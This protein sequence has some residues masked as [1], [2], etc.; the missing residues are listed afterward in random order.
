[1]TERPSPPLTLQVEA[2]P[3][4][5]R[6]CVAGDLDYDTSDQLVER[7]QECVEADPALREVVLECAG[8]RV[9]DSMGVSS[10]LMLHRGTSAR[11]IRL[12]LDDPPPF[13]SRILY[14][15]GTGHLFGVAAG[16]ARGPAGLPED[17][18]RPGDEPYRSFP[19]SAPS[20]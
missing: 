2:S 12:S 7:F 18:P 1:M 17:G 3:G 5:V 13:L 20:G 8:L 14:V 4:V 6:L 9:C 10:L 11:G 19:P 15:T 16:G